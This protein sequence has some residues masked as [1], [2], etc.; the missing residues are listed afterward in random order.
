MSDSLK[1]FQ[2]KIEIRQF[3][4]NNSWKADTTASGD[5]VYRDGCGLEDRF[6]LWDENIVEADSSK[7][8][9]G[10]FPIYSNKKH[11]GGFVVFCKRAVRK[12]M[13]IF[14]GWYIFPILEHA[15]H[16]RGKIVNAVALERELIVQQQQKINTLLDQVQKITNSQKESEKS[17]RKAR[18]HAKKLEEQM[19]VLMG[20]VNTL[21]A[22]YE[23]DNLEMSDDFYH[24]FEEAFRGSRE[25]IKTR[26]Q[27]YVPIIRKHLSDWG[28][29]TFIDVGSG[30]GEWLDVL[31]E[32]GA[33]DYIGVDLN[34]TQNKICEERGHRTICMDCI[35]YLRE[36][37]EKSVDLVTGFQIIEHLPLPIFVQLVEECKRVLKPGGML[38]FETQNPS[39]LS[40]GADTFYIDPSH[41]RPL[42]PRL[43]EFLVKWCGFEQ[44]QIIDANTTANCMNFNEDMLG[45]ENKQ[46]VH[47][48]NDISWKLFGPQDY[49][50]FAV[51]GSKE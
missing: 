50:I 34:Q 41:I 36:R 18:E 46:L 20:E 19:V 48:I 1:E 51:K 15:N 26:L 38:L 35:Q 8:T 39:N 21:R 16:F 45:Q 11:I 2:R 49:A 14:M 27:V 23:R 30:R 24:D 28:K 33:S 5:S 3:A 4:I 29:G 12:I 9:N 22:E 7:F 25:D 17:E 47:H 10:Y 44:T 6:A 31:K 42:D 37:P 40:V 32:N 13:K 43:I